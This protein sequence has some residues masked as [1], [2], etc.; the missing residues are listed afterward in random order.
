MAQLASFDI[1][2]GVDLQEVD[3]AVNQATKEIMQRY[4]FKG[5]NCSIAFDRAKSVLHLDADD[6]YRLKAL[7]DVL[8]SKFV[9]RGVPLK[10]MKPGSVEPASGG[11]VRQEVTL[12]QGIPTDTAKQ[13]VKD[14]KAHGGFKKVQVAIQGDQLRVSS[15][16]R[17]ELQEVIAFLKGQDYGIELAFGNY[18]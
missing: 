2:S 9:K 5:T 10:N 1:T 15:P 13:I 17:D 3:N 4:D 6:D 8:Q 12:T 11:R 18:R 16:S 14:V 7:Y